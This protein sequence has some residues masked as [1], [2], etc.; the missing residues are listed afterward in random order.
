MFVAF[1][2][3]VPGVPVWYIWIVVLLG[4]FFPGLQFKSLNLVVYADIENGAIGRATSLS[5]VVQPN[6]TRRRRG[7]WRLC[8]GDHAFAERPSAC[9]VVGL[10]A[11]IA[12]RRFWLDWLDSDHSASSA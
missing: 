9:D 6:V 10:L 8:A 4:G 11:G 2:T 5:A 12:H 1:G 3:F 7:R